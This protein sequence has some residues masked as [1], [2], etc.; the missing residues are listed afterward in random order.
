MEG[1][2]RM[3][4]HHDEGFTN[5]HHHAFRFYAFV[6]A[7]VLTA[8][9]Y[10]VQMGINWKLPPG[11]AIPIEFDR[12]LDAAK[13]KPGNTVKATTMQVIHLGQNQDIPKGSLVIGHVTMARPVRRGISPSVLAFSFDQIVTRRGVLTVPLYVR[14]LSNTIE[15]LDAS[16]PMPPTDM[17]LSE[18]RVLIG[19]DQVT[20][21]NLK[22]YSPESE[23]EG[24][25]IVGENL[26]AGIFERL[27]S[28]QAMNGNSVLLCDG[29]P[30]EQ[31]IAIYSGDAC[32][33]YGFDLVYLAHTGKR[34]HGIV[35]IESKYFTIKLY[36]TSTALLQV[37]PVS[38]DSKSGI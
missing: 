37:A 25:D 14:A 10:A 28:A 36:S 12:T 32:G 2:D 30:T 22:V 24:L 15:S 21:S 38:H 23:D 7:L 11:T 27:R 13:L 6:L 1:L 17:N 26:K 16:Y 4:R 5:R 8:P 31:S 9:C 35:E 19:G 29:T 18:V 34:N 33:L 3:K 20:P